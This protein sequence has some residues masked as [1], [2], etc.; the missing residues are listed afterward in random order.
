MSSSFPSVHQ[1]RLTKQGVKQTYI[2]GVD[3]T[4]QALSTS[5]S[6][7]STQA[8]DRATL[9]KRIDELEKRVLQELEQLQHYIR[10]SDKML[11]S[12][13]VASHGP[14]TIWRLSHFSLDCIRQEFAVHAPELFNLFSDNSP[15]HMQL[16]RLEK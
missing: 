6:S 16:Y 10:E 11:S 5:P 13:N 2:T 7:S 4:E 15:K 14:D 3:W 1:K 9:K 8:S 12:S